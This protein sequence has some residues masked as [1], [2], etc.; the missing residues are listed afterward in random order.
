MSK[1]YEWLNKEKSR[2]YK[3]SIEKDDQKGFALKHSWGG[4]YSNRVGSKY[5]AMQTE[6]DTKRYLAY[7][8]KRRKSRGY[9]LLTPTVH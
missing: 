7:M 1:I 5:V 8:V 3:V 2:F 6:E 4:C 9:E